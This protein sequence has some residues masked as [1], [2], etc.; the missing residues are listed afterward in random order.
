MKLISVK[1][2]ERLNS[3]ELNKR[4]KEYEDIENT[5]DYFNELIN[6]I[7][8]FNSFH[9]N[10]DSYNL[11]YV[12][13]N[14]K[15]GKH[16]IFR[17]YVGLIQLKNKLQIEILPKIDFPESD[18]V[19]EKEVKKNNKNI[20]L[21]M[22]KSLKDFEGK[23]FNEAHLKID[24]MNLYEVFINMY[25]NELLR[26]VKK[27]LHSNYIPIEDNLNVLKGKL[28]IKD[29]IRKNY[30]NKAKFYVEYD[31]YQLNKPMNKIIKS[32]LLKLELYS[33][34]NNNKKMIRRL[35]LYFELVEPSLNYDA[36][37]NKI[38]FNR[39]NKDYEWIINWSRVFLKNNS[40]TNFSG[41]S[42]STALLFQMDKLFES[43]VAKHIKSQ[44]S[45]DFEVSLKDRKYF[46]F[47]QPQK[48]RLEP[49]I[50]LRNKMNNKI[51]LLDTKWK[52][53]IDNKNKNYDI[54]TA[55]MYQM[56]AY[57]QKYSTENN[58]V[59]VWLLYPLNQEMFEYENKIIS[60][61]GCNDRKIDTVVNV[62]FINLANVEKS[63][64]FLKKEILERTNLKDIL[65]SNEV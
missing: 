33:T 39:S 53:L 43:F 62:Y 45:I 56:Y 19:E 59:E 50:V 44:F 42:K 27:G 63:V 35:L 54:S 15:L 64:E 12:R 26:L 30:V 37:F 1:E 38:V 32:T 21:N 6:F 5:D 49:D 46:L 18:C 20:F 29:Q 57:S 3:Q 34:D 41:S 47:D 23:S 25:L 65:I 31:E 51:I 61:I 60:Y 55:D 7:D 17:N 8:E 14:R 28:L 22:I 16:V 10:I 13:K 58:K 36:D 52:N 24:R 48:F 4:L 40:F 9:N 2:Y 11:M